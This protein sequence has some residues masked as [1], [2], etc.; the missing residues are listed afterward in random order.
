MTG[1]KSLSSEQQDGFVSL[2]CG[3]VILDKTFCDD[4]EAFISKLLAGDG[5]PVDQFYDRLEQ[6]IGEPPREVCE[7]ALARL[8]SLSFEQKEWVLE[9]LFELSLADDFLHV[10]E[11]AFLE[12][13]NKYWGLQVY[14]GKGQLNWTEQQKEIISADP[15]ARFIVNAMPG[16]GKT[17]VACAK[18]SNLIDEGVTPSNIWLVSFTRTAVQELRDR[19]AS[20]ADEEDDVIGVKIAT[21]DSRA[22][23]L[24][25]GMR[26]DGTKSLFD[27][28]DLSISNAIDVLDES[29]EE[30]EDFFGELEHVIIDEAQD[31]TGVRLAFIEKIIERL[32][33]SCGVSIFGD[34]AQAIYGFTNDNIEF[35]STDSSENLM[36]LYKSEP[37]AGFEYRE[38]E[39]MHRTENQSLL[40]LIDTLRVQIQVDEP[41]DVIAPKETVKA[42]KAAADTS[43]SGFDAAD[44]H[45]LNNT[46]ILFRRRSDV[47]Q[48]C[49]FAN[50]QNLKYRVRMS[51]MPVV[52]R[53]WIGQLFYAQ[54]TEVISK[55]DFFELWQAKEDELISVGDTQ[56]SAAKRLED[57]AT[58]GHGNISL[59]DLRNQIAMSVPPVGLCVPDLG[60][61]GPTIG[62]IHASKG[63]QAQNVTL[64]LG[65][66][67]KS[68]EQSEAEAEETR[69]LFVGA[70]RAE[71]SLSVGP[72]FRS[73]SKSLSSGRTFVPNR[74]LDRKNAAQVEIGRAGD[75]DAL[76]L[77][78]KSLV[79][80]NEAKFLQ[81]LILEIS[82]KGGAPV[83]ARR[84]DRADYVYDLHLPTY[85]ERWI[86][87]F[88]ANIN[89]DLWNV[90]RALSQQRTRGLPKEIRHLKLFGTT[91]FA[92]RDDE[93]NAVL[94]ETLVTDAQQS[95]VWCTPIIIGFPTLF[96]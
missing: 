36:G 77:V 38:L 68:G 35:A 69:V 17:A 67:S 87:R 20:F 9:T 22:W 14:F 52:C 66:N 13:V 21:I 27:N 12:D 1:F 45:G 63:R 30:L 57:Y 40:N 10:E 89:K 72:G 4:E 25:Y 71:S 70:S 16:A 29:S 60:G 28:Y 2:L 15:D 42:I 80:R 3:F 32:P 33:H 19:I 44:L 61:E 91:T 49:S 51:G 41:E 47:L 94:I 8:A 39:S 64:F 65:S 86:G 31:I 76:S 43:V 88:S 78:S 46:L 96:F 82:S 83:V 5:I 90:K 54:D 23:Q 26:S 58:K 6:L 24:R 73:F 55:Q 84:N 93:K 81:E 92:I 34:D 7:E 53:P 11:K 62:T 85:S 48:A 50:Q 95:G 74:R 59:R 18:I 56:F 79:N 75:F 37:P